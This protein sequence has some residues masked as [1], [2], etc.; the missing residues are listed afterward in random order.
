MVIV[1]AIDRSDRAARVVAEA[2]ALAEAFDDSIHV[3]HVIGQRELIDIEETSYEQTGE[4]FSM[5][6]MEGFAAEVAE[7]AS[8]GLSV[9]HDAVGLVGS[10]AEEV[11]RYADDHDA[12]FIV[13]GGR[14]QSPTGKALF[15]S[16]GQSILLKAT[17]PV[18]STLDAAD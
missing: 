6:E 8:E 12:R 5:D 3:V 4:V 9:D 17:C 13:V 11:V 10:A 18:V 15:G 2:A 1:A 16:V 7:Q 14:R